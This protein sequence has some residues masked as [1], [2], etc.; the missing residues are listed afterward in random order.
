[1]FTNFSV[2]SDVFNS[3]SDLEIWDRTTQKRRFCS[4]VRQWLLE[5]HLTHPKSAIKSEG[6]FPKINKC[7]QLLSAELI[8]GH[9]TTTATSRINKPVS[10]PLPCRQIDYLDCRRPEAVSSSIK[11]KGG[12]S[13]GDSVPRTLLNSHSND[14][15]FIA[16]SLRHHRSQEQQHS[17][18]MCTEKDFDE[19]GLPNSPIGIVVLPEW[20]SIVSFSL[21]SSSL[22][23]C[24]DVQSLSLHVSVG[25]FFLIPSHKLIELS[26]GNQNIRFL[27]ELL[28]SPM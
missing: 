25:Y 27:V 3:F 6:R 16:N 11:I 26:N 19:I 4:L 20:L 7:F 18:N 15:L 13:S 21:S 22:F 28:V 2:D 1:M 23:C 12:S 9:S 10:D 14:R 8:L 24:S 17:I 5:F